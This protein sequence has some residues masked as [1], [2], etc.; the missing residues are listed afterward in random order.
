MGDIVEVKRDEFVVWVGGKPRADWKGLDDDAPKEYL[1]AFQVRTVSDKKYSERVA[2]PAEENEKFNKKTGDFSRFQDNLQQHLIKHGMDTIAYLR[3]PLDSTKM[4]FIISEHPKYTLTKVKELMAEQIKLYDKYDRNNNISARDF[5]LNSLEKSF[6]RQV[7]DQSREVSSFPELFMVVVN[8]VTHDSPQHW[9]QVKREMRSLLP[10]NYGGQD[11][12]ALTQNFAEKAR[13]LIAAGL[14]DHTLTGKLLANIITADW[15]ETPKF[16]LMYISKNLTDAITEIRFL[17]RSVADAKMRK[18]KLWYT[19]IIESA[20]TKYLVSLKDG[21]WAPKRSATDSKA[22]PSSFGANQALVPSSKT[23]KASRRGRN[24]AKPPLTQAALNALIQTLKH[25]PGTN[26]T[27]TKNPPTNHGNNHRDKGGKRPQH[28]KNNSRVDRSQAN[29]WKTIPPGPGESHTKTVNGVLQYWCGKCTRWN[30][31]HTTDQHIV[32]FKRNQRNTKENRANKLE[33]DVSAWCTEIETPQDTEDWANL[34][35]C[36]SLESMELKEDSQQVDLC[37]FVAS[38]DNTNAQENDDSTTTSSIHWSSTT[39]SYDNLPPLILRKGTNC[40]IREVNYCVPTEN[41]KV[42]TGLIVD[43]SCG[44]NDDLSSQDET[45]DEV[46]KILEPEA[47]TLYFDRWD[48]IDSWYLP[49]DK[50]VQKGAGNP[51]Q[52]PT[53]VYANAAEHEASFDSEQL[54]FESDATQMRTHNTSMSSHQDTTQESSVMTDDD[55]SITP[56]KGLQQGRL[57]SKDEEGLDKKPAAYE[58]EISPIVAIDSPTQQALPRLNLAPRSASRLMQDWAAAMR[59]QPTHRPTFD[60]RIF[61]EEAAKAKRDGMRYERAQYT[62]YALQH[63][64]PT[65]TIG[66]AYQRVKMEEWFIGW[67]IDGTRIPNHPHPLPEWPEL[68]INS[69]PPPCLLRAR[70]MEHRPEELG[71]RHRFVAF[72]NQSNA[73]PS[74]VNISDPP[75]VNLSSRSKACENLEEMAEDDTANTFST[76]SMNEEFTLG[77][78]YVPTP[79]RRAPS[80]PRREAK[81]GRKENPFSEF[82]AMTAIVEEGEE[83]EDDDG[84]ENEDDNEQEAET[85]NNQNHPLSLED[86]EKMTEELISVLDSKELVEAFCV[87]YNLSEDH[88]KL[89]G[90]FCRAARYI[91]LLRHLLKTE[92]NPDNKNIFETDLHNQKEV[93]KVL[94]AFLHE[95]LKLPNLAHRDKFCTLAM[96]HDFAYELAHG[97]PMFYYVGESN[98]NFADDSEDDNTIDSSDS[99]HSSTATNQEQP[100][101]EAYYAGFNV[102]AHQNFGGQRGM[103]VPDPRIRDESAEPPSN[104]T[105]LTNPKILASVMSLLIILLSILWLLP[106]PQSIDHANT[107]FQEG[108]TSLWQGIT[109]LWVGTGNVSYGIYTILWSLTLHP[110]YQPALFAWICCWVTIFLLSPTKTPFDTACFSFQPKLQRAINSSRAA[111]LNRILELVMSLQ[112]LHSSARLIVVSVCKLLRMEQTEAKCPKKGGET[113][114]DGQCKI[115]N[116]PKRAIHKRSKHKSAFRPIFPAP[117]TKR[118]RMRTGIRRPTMYRSPNASCCVTPRDRYQHSH[119]NNRPPFSTFDRRNGNTNNRHS[120]IFRDKRSSIQPVMGMAAYLEEAHTLS[121]NNIFGNSFEG[122]LHYHEWN[123]ITHAGLQACLQ[124]PSALRNAMP[125]SASY[126]II[127]DSGA[128]LS[129]TNSASD[130][131]GPI[132]PMP[133]LKVK[134]I[135]NR[136]KATGRGYVLWSFLDDGGKIRS[137]KLPAYLVPKIGVRLLSTQSLLQTY[138]GE[139]IIQDGKTMVLTGMPESQDR[140]K[141]TIV[142]NPI[143]NLPMTYGY[144]KREVIRSSQALTSIVSTT[145][146]QNTNLSEP[147][148]ELVRWHYRLGHLSLRRIQFVMRT[149]ILAHSEQQRRLHAK[150]AS[151]TDLPLCAACQYGKQKR[152]PQPGTTSS[153]V[154]DRSGI[155]KGENLYP[156]QCISVDHF[157]CS[158]KGRR[159]ETRGVLSSKDLYMGGAIFVDHA[160]GY[161]WIGFQSHLNTHETLH[162]KNSFEL[163][164]RDVGVVPTQYLTDNGSAF[165]SQKYTESLQNFAR[166][167]RFAGVGAHHHAGVAERA[168]QTIMSIAR[169]MMLHAAIHWPEMADPSLWPMAVAHAT[170]LCNHVPSATHGISP[171]DLFTRTR[172]EQRKFHDLHVWGCPVYVLDKSMGDGKKLPRWQPRSNRCI[173]MGLSTRH[174]TTVPLV[175]NPSTGYITPQYHVVFDDWFTTIATSVEDKPDFSSDD[176]NKLFGES[177]YQ[178]IED[179]DE[180]NIEEPTQI[181]TAH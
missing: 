6:R 165:T 152:R 12:M 178:Y 31:T 61:E 40:C 60:P 22:P 71:T 130:F 159:F 147:Q 95:T 9:E 5:L 180:E 47:N 151:L 21:E 83:E 25:P 96:V 118:A 127:W 73:T 137:L 145:S 117:V 172:W 46:M 97:Q 16:E 45:S 176:W 163:F 13:P 72:L 101:V 89:D 92:T 11:I 122:N 108:T 43:S 134:G 54:N 91:L 64:E 66:E 27:P 113:N 177:R 53:E 143:N 126:P 150:A 171:H 181:D 149:G 29:P 136:M 20:N 3:N 77:S 17:D 119:F 34:P 26:P 175:L 132:L 32:G 179:D 105:I 57:A 36:M 90:L 164:C 59:P 162:V 107:T 85:G 103:H 69:D 154:K 104:S 111:S 174:A 42:P 131:I 123:L 37:A 124:D 142:I 116:T 120:D 48:N 141:V 74:P 50:S 135:A 49:N 100:T 88:Q 33:I 98:W 19:D 167:Y 2:G 18:D 170:F 7:Q 168:I 153:I 67:F 24:T 35:D 52:I 156:G 102:N 51:P 155:T 94:W 1:R 112:F 68:Q 140:T 160:S 82:Y 148:K 63:Q 169:T 79:L 138:D 173:L 75:S 70:L 99:D 76:S 115:R 106:T 121:A 30:D 146:E 158:T 14:Y 114:N 161:T 84:E 128:S 93:V 44:G 15:P 41:N 38:V 8:I 39:T 81:R 23:P 56:I 10:Q 133:D 129:I 80:D 110:S 86:Y 87:E 58:P 65:L 28:K 157:V 139:K 144:D 125:A 55:V 62:I 166:T 78:R 109:Q 4:L